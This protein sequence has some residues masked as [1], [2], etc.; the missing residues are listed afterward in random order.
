[1]H[2][3]RPGL[4][5]TAI[6]QNHL[7][8]CCIMKDKRNTIKEIEMK[9]VQPSVTLEWATPNALQMIERAGRTAYKSEDAITNES[10]E[11]FVRRT[12][13]RNHTAVLE[14]ADASFR[15]IFDRG[16]S[17]E[18]VRHRI[19]SYCQESTRFCNY[20]KG[21]F[22]GEITIIQPDGLSEA[23]TERR[24]KLLEMIE[25]VYLAEI[26][27]GLSPQIAR[28]ILPTCLKTEIVCKTNFSEWRH[29]LKL[30]TAKDAHP[31]IRQA[32]ALVLEWFRENY[33]VIVEDIL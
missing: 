29:I 22:N 13:K 32:M 28:G 21:K 11:D 5:K 18:L 1:M 16:V 2:P 3:W 17:H 33:P 24:I 15:F 25:E 4:I 26:S 31:Q 7:R 6:G 19:A 10:A 23:Q 8:F 12:V 20:S 30:R 27:D 14:H 9:I